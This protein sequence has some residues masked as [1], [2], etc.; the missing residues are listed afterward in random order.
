M[1]V[2][3]SLIICAFDGQ[4][5]AEAAK[6]SI[7]ELG[8]QIQEMQII[9]TA[10]V[11]KNDRGEVTFHEPGNAREIAV[12][13]AG[14]LAKGVSWL[15]YNV[16]GMLGPL[17]GV[18]A[19]EQAKLTIERFTKDTGFPDEAL[20]ELGA[21]L[22]AGHAALIALIDADDRD[23]VVKLLADLGGQVIDGSIPPD[24]L[25]RLQR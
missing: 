18:S 20:L 11:R 3:Q 6:N 25:T 14:A 24:L 17:A 8:N 5:E 1:Q 9:R 13:V 10:I 21:R 2:S 16:A 7:D 19:E 4:V 23:E 22:D 12:D 15:I